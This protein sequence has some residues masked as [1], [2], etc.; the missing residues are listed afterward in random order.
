MKFPPSTVQERNGHIRGLLRS[1]ESDVRE[2]AEA[3]WEGLPESR[4]SDVEAVARHCKFKSSGQEVLVELLRLMAWEQ[5]RYL[6][7]IRNEF[8]TYS[9]AGD[10]GLAMK[11]DQLELAAEYLAAQRAEARL[12]LQ[13]PPLTWDGLEIFINALKDD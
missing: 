3:L 8:G 5:G 10:T 13:D 4:H 7:R 12:N 9:G 1:F 11:I 2:C 6:R